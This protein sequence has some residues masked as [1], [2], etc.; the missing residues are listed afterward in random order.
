MN[1]PAYERAPDWT[2]DQWVNTKDDI[3]LDSL[4]GKVVVLHAFQMLCPGCVSH[5]IPQAKAIH[6]AFPPDKLR[7]IGLHT[8]F[9]HHEAMALVSL[10][11]FIHEYRIHFPVAIDQPAADGPI[12]VTM[13]AYRLQG[14]PSLILIDK[15]GNI[16]LHHFGQLDDLRAGAAIGQLLS[17]D[18][19]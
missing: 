5:G 15:V 19:G 14:T 6:N 9:E 10:K 18:V 16:R 13:Q 1:A 3:T 7:V 2:L 12:P 4:R 8:V 11:A 17:E